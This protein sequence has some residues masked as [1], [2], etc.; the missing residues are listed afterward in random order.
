[1]KL[2]EPRKSVPEYGQKGLVIFSKPAS[3][4]IHVPTK[5]N[6]LLNPTNQSLRVTLY[7]TGVRWAGELST[8]WFA[9]YPVCVFS[10]DRTS[11]GMRKVRF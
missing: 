10:L 5:N 11:L 7:I 1:M 3:F 4:L 9:F 6:S 8:S 2:R